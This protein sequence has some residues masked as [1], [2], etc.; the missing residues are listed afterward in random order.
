MQAP[1]RDTYMR[2]NGG[3]TITGAPASSPVLYG[4][5]L[6]GRRIPTLEPPASAILT[7]RCVSKLNECLIHQRLLGRETVDHL[8]RFA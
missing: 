4:P 2:R 3:H 6:Q 7:R 1:G 5:L 8:D